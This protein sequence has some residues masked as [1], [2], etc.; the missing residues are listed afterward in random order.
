M[1]I[2]HSRASMWKTA[3]ATGLPSLGGPFENFGLGGLAVQNGKLYSIV[4]NNPQALGNPADLCKGAPD[5]NS[6]VATMTAVVNDAGTLNGLKS[7][8]S[9]RGWKTLA[10]VGRFDFNYA[11]AHPDPGNPEYA[12]GDADPFGLTA[13]PSG[14]FYVI[15]AASNTLDFV[16]RRGDISV[17]AF[18]PDPPGHKPIY[19][20]APTCAARMQN[21]N[22]VI[23]TESNSLWRWNGRK[24]T[25]LL[26][27]G[28]LG[29]IV[30]CVADRNGNIYLANLASQVIPGLIE[31]PF[32][33][34]I[35]KVTPKLKT[36]YI[37]RGLNLPTGLTLGP[38]GHLY[39]AING[40]CP[41]DLSLLTSQNSPP[42]ACPASG[43]VVRLEGP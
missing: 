5:V 17:L 6:C 21:G 20:A 4:Q 22:L 36:S 38:D 15:D 31:K 42:G 26:S 16:S 41:S 9:N 40:L 43:K 1:N 39:V 23:G 29:Q 24:L 18:I 37:V 14:G 33:G 35:V 8:T 19:D 25:R 12:P 28:K 11:A 13:G 30:G 32:D 2:A 10:E 27:G 3:L 7:L 34:S